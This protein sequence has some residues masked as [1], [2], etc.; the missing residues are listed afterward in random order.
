MRKPNKH[1][2]GPNTNLNGLK[3]E[4]RTNFI[5]SII[6]NKNFYVEH[7][8]NFKKTYKIFLKEK[9]YGYYT[10]K[11]EFYKFFLKKE[12][13][14]WEKIISKKYLPDAVFINDIIKTV[15]VIEKKFQSRSGSVDEKLQT[16]DF[17]KKI[18]TKI[19]KKS[20]KNYSVEYF[21]IL[22][23][24]FKRSEYNDVKKYI[25]S[26]NCNYFIEEVTFKYLGLE[27]F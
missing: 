7:V 10:E 16:C 26:V 19:I 3:F 17:K 8:K 13:I 9:L 23:S 6:N 27:N 22:N 11:N 20:L 12:K 25:K 21:F 5:T 2:G 15:F 4:G 1:G 14:I 18:Y 24:W